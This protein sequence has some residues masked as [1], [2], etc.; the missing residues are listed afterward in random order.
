M[1]GAEGMPMVNAQP[2]VIARLTSKELIEIVAH[3]CIH[4]ANSA[5]ARVLDREANA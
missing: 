5:C 2:E 4:A 3:G 1:G